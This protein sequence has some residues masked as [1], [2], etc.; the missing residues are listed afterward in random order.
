MQPSPLCPRADAAARH[1]GRLAVGLAVPGRDAPTVILDFTLVPARTLGWSRPDF[2]SPARHK[3]RV[4]PG[5][6]GRVLATSWACP[7]CSARLSTGS[8]FTG[9][10]PSV[11]RCR[12]RPA[13]DR[14]GVLGYRLVVLSVRAVPAAAAAGPGPRRVGLFRLDA[15]PKGGGLDLRRSVPDPR[16]AP[17]LRLHR[18][19]RPIRRRCARAP[20][21]DPWLA[22]ADAALG[23]HVPTL[24]CGRARTR[25]SSGSYF[26]ATRVFCRSSFC[27][28][29]CWGSGTGT[30]RRSG[31]RLSLPVCLVVTLV[32]FALF[33]AAC[34]FSFYGFESISNKR[35]SSL[36]SATCGRG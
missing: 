12:W 7:R 10:A 5:R 15:G 28:S 4:W 21:A 27:R 16:A 8:A 26:A 11:S 23:V 2:R 6:A 3:R 14:L 18:R 1:P 29:S 34:A 32:C 20:L 36:T 17:R 35:G 24:V 33:P 13:P 30:A 9:S 19:A 25:G 31:I 22:A